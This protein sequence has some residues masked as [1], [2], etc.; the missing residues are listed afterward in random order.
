M[1]L[2]VYDL[3]FHPPHSLKT[4]LCTLYILIGGS[5]VAFADVNT[6][7][8]HSEMLRMPAKERLV[9][10]RNACDNAIGK[11]DE[12]QYDLLKIYIAEAQKQASTVDEMYG[13][14]RLMCYYYNYDK[15]KQLHK[16]LP[17]AMNKMIAY[18]YTDYY[19]ELWSLMIEQHFYTEKI[20]QALSEAKELFDDAKKRKNGYGLAVA[21]NLLGEIY[22]DMY[23]GVIS[24]R[25]F[26]IAVEYAKKLKHN[27][28]LLILIYSNYTDALYNERQ[29]PQMLKV[30]QEWEEKLKEHAEKIKKEGKS[31]SPLTPWYAYCY[32]AIADA[33]MQMGNYDAANSYLQK[34]AS[35][36]NSQTI[37]VKSAYYHSISQF[38][39]CKKDYEKALEYS[40]MC[41]K[42]SASIKDAMGMNSLL[43]DH[44]YILNSA[45]RYKEASQL[46][47]SLMEKRDSL[48]ENYMRNQLNEMSVNYQLENERANRNQANMN[49]AISLS[50]LM[51]SILIG[52]LYYI[53]TRKLRQRERIMFKTVQRFKLTERLNLA[54]LETLSEEKLTMEERLFIETCQMMDRDK[55]YRD[56][57][58]NR[59]L[60]ATL[61]NTNRTYLGSAIRK[62]ADGLTISEFITRYRLRYAA[63]LLVGRPD[64]NI[65]DTGLMAGFNS[66]STYNRLFRNFFGVSPTSFRDIRVQSADER[67][68][69][70]DNV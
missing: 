45:G 40:N 27:N 56:P 2:F 60:M 33:Q 62:Y 48:E 7:T 22:A 43:I 25:H 47:S 70:A 10:L 37:R 29:Y 67:S 30:A 23:D 69:E 17:D 59:D 63:A 44:A 66:R 16:E 15:D 8:V 9:Y 31:L 21:N 53:Y 34:V 64:M 42:I 41:L 55:P 52:V 3:L 11:D 35:T 46:Y 28:R 5:S 24:L 6:A 26:A 4:V 39:A 50:A 12:K 18:G 58:F 36:I 51:I 38:W 19:Y 61:L 1:K 54:S 13:L 14:K 49:L 68:S 57:D 32:L 65:N 20:I